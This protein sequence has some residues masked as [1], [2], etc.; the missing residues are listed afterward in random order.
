M[1][2]RCFNGKECLADG[3]NSSVMEGPRAVRNSDREFEEMERLE[4]EA[5]AQVTSFSAADR[6]SRDDVHNRVLCRE[7]V[8]KLVEE[9]QALLGQS[10]G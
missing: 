4:R 9:P 2:T 1:D 5:R 10:K 7:R 8:Q 6:L 3:V